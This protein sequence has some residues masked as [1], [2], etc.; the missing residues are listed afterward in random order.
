MQVIM[1]LDNKIFFV[2]L[3]TCFISVKIREQGLYVHG[4][5]WWKRGIYE[6]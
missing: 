2:S 1:K 4:G 5:Y 3:T 6:R